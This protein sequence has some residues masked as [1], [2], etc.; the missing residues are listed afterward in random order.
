MDTHAVKAEWSPVKNQED[1]Q[2]LVVL[3]DNGTLFFLS[4]PFQ[5]D[6]IASDVT[7]FSIAPLGDQVAYIKRNMLYVIPITGGQPR[8]LAEEAFG[9]PRWALSENAM[10]FPSSPVKIAY[11]DGSGAFIPQGASSITERIEYLCHGNRSCA[12]SSNIEAN[13]VLW[14]EKSH[15]LVFYKHHANDEE[16]FRTV[17]AYEL[18]EDLGKIVNR[19]TIFG[20]FTNRIQWDTAGESIIDSAGNKAIFGSPPEIFTVH[21]K[22]NS[23][24]DKGFIAEFMWTTP[25]NTHRY[26]HQFVHVT[27][28]DQ[29]Q[30]VDINGQ[31]T[32]MDTFRPGMTIKL[33]ARKLSP[34]TLSLFAYKIHISCDQ[35][36]CY[37]GFEGRS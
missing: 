3:D 11:L 32:T 15:L 4:D 26:G 1:I 29:S 25:W 18:S 30:I 6:P 9:T 20:D 12:L 7:H 17:Y 5:A 24:E 23:V 8:K 37:L 14:D 19:Q 34:Y 31:L 2:P 27:I 13:H 22:I 21:A 10:I 35:F 16:N 28:N 33:T 36:P